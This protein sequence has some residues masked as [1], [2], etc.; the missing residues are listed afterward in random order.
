MLGG[1]KVDP[2]IRPVGRVCS[3]TT[4]PLGQILSRIE[5]IIKTAPQI[6]TQ[7]FDRQGLIFAPEDR[8]VVIFP[9]KIDGQ[10]LAFHRP[11]P[12]HIGTPAMWLARSPDL[13]YWGGHQKLVDVR[14]DCWDCVRVGAGAV[15]FRTPKGWLE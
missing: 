6:A 12:K 1:K 13:K 10:Y 4:G 14:P 5:S 7:T 3:K 9:E 2:E 8:D 11:Y 15:P